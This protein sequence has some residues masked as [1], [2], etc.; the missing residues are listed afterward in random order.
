MY[1]IRNKSFYNQIV[2]L[3]YKYI[4]LPHMHII[5]PYM[6]KLLPYMYANMQI[7]KIIANHVSILRRIPTFVI[8]NRYS[9]C[10]NNYEYY[11]NCLAVAAMLI[12]QS[13]RILNSEV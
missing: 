3:P 10:K 5:L 1:I 2:T 12:C 8:Y 11:F 13:G 9:I 4:I 7:K 6:Y